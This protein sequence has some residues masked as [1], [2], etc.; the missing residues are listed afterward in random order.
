M[1]WRR[2]ERHLW[3]AERHA[4]D[5]P[6]MRRRQQ[7]GM[8]QRHGERPPKRVPKKV[9]RHAATRVLL[10][11]GVQRDVVADCPQEATMEKA[12]FRRN[13]RGHEQVQLKVMR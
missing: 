7:V 2:T 10:K 1:R 9:E 13:F 4:G 5:M 11:R 8:Q 3:R 6:H 12:P